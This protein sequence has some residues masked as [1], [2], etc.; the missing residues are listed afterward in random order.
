MLEHTGMELHLP[1]SSICQDICRPMQAAK[2]H[3]LVIGWP[4]KVH[5]VCQVCIKGACDLSE[6]AIPWL[7]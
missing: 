5:R 3:E 4:G 2:A 1:S 6:P 7:F